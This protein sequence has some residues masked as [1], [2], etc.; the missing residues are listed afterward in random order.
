[1][2]QSLFLATRSAAVQSRTLNGIRAVAINLVSTSTNA[3]VIAA[4]VAKLN[5][6][7]GATSFDSKYFDTVIALGDLSGG[8][9]NADT[10]SMF[11]ADRADPVVAT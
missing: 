7:G 10:V 2:V 1:M 6:K 3:Q 8:P 9:L 5:L 4:A 11:F